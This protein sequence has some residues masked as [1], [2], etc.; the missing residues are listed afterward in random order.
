[1]KI[2]TLLMAS[3]FTASIAKATSPENLGSGYVCNAQFA[4]G[5]QLKIYF[6]NIVT[7]RYDGK[8][9][10]RL[11]VD[12]ISRQPAENVLDVTGM[13]VPSPG[14]PEGPTIS[15]SNL[16]FTLSEAG[17]VTYDLTGAFDESEISGTCTYKRRVHRVE[18]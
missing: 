6:T 14:G 4:D 7:N 18:L 16:S 13:Y 3:L 11:I 15:Y 9:K 17:S 10:G 8:G 1:M 12:N 5:T 2:L